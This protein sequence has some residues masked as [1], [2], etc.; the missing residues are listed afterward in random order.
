[1]NRC[2]RRRVFCWPQRKPVVLSWCGFFLVVRL[3]PFRGWEAVSFGR[4]GRPA[5]MLWQ[6]P[7]GEDDE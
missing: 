5:V 2:I 1:M 7:T 4:I 3:L 6:S